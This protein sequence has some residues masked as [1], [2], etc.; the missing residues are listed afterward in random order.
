MEKTIRPFRYDLNQITN[1]YTVDMRNIFKGL[2]L[3][4][5]VPGELWTEVHDIVEE[6]GVKTIPKEKKCKKA[7]WLSWEALQIAVKRR[8]AKSKGE[9]ERYTHLSAEFQRIA[10]RDKKAF[11]NDQCS[12]IEESNRM[13]KT[14]DI[15]KKIRDTKGIFCAKM[16]SVKGKNGLEL[17]EAEDIKRRQEYT[18]ELYKKD[19]HDPDNHDGGITHL[20]SDILECEVKWALGSITTNKVSGDDG[21]PVELFQILEDDAVKMLHSTCQQIWKTQQWPQDWKRSVFI[22]SQRKAIPKNVQTTT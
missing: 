13:G 5:R 20:E 15:F 1:D 12:E 6:T 4:G 21:I 14:R 9:K 2:D 10:R 3:I 18:E 22:Q 8:E 16:G 7:K 11:L 19:L 17:T